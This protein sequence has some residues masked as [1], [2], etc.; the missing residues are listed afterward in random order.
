MKSSTVLFLAIFGF[1][2]LA[3][4]ATDNRNT[5]VVNHYGIEQGLTSI[6]IIDLD[7]DDSGLI[8]LVTSDGLYQFDGIQFHKHS[9]LDNIPL[10]RK[11]SQIAIHGEFA[12]ISINQQLIIY[13]LT[14]GQTAHYLLEDNTARII[15]ILPFSQTHSLVGTSNGLYQVSI[16]QFMHTQ[17]QKIQNSTNISFNTLVNYNSSKALVSESKGQ[18][19]IYD[20][21]TQKLTQI[22]DL[23]EE[24]SDIYYD[25][26]KKHWWLLLKHQIVSLETH[27]NKWRVKDTIIPYPNT[28]EGMQL[29]TSHEDNLYLATRM[30][31]LTEMRLNGKI[32]PL[33]LKT[34]AGALYSD[35][36]ITKIK[37]DD[38]GNLWI[39]SFDE[40]L[41]KLSKE[42]QAMEWLT[43]LPHEKNQL[44]NNHVRAV[45]MTKN[46]D[47]WLGFYNQ[48]ITRFSKEQEKVFQY[49]KNKTQNRLSSDIIWDFAEDLS[50]P[51]LWIATHQTGVSCFDFS[52]ENFCDLSQFRIP[53][54]SAL[55]V[56]ATQ[57]NKW[58]AMHGGLGQL[59]D[60]VF[61]YH[62][63]PPAEHEDKPTA[64]ALLNLTIIDDEVFA[65]SNRGLYV[66][67]QQQKKLQRVPGT[68]SMH[69]NHLLK[70][71]Q[72]LFLATDDGLFILDLNHKKLESYLPTITHNKS[73]VSM[74][75]LENNLWVVGEREIIGINIDTHHYQKVGAEHLIPTQFYLGATFQDHH[76]WLLGSSRG[77]LQINLEQLTTDIHTRP[78]TRANKLIIRHN[79]KSTHLGYY[80]RI[81]DTI[82]LPNKSDS[83]HVTLSSSFITGDAAFQYR[84]NEGLWIPTRSQFNLIPTYWRYGENHLSF[85]HIQANGVE[86]Y[87]S[88]LT[89]IKPTP[90]WH[91]TLAYITYVILFILGN[92]LFIQWRHRSSQL[93]QKALE[94]KIEERTQ[95]LIIKNATIN[96]QAKDLEHLVESKDQMFN[97]VTHELKTP[98]ALMLGPLQLLKD[99]FNDDESFKWFTI[100]QRNGERL[101]HSIDTLLDLQRYAALQ[102]STDLACNVTQVTEYLVESFDSIINQKSL[103]LVK[104]IKSDVW[105]QADAISIEKIIIN[106]LSNAFKY[107]P[108]HSRILLTIEYQD[109]HG[110]IQVEDSGPGIPAELRSK[111]FQPFY[112]QTIHQK[113]SGSGV[114]LAL[115]KKIVD[116][117]QGEIFITAS[118]NEGSIF[119]VQL[120]RAKNLPASSK[121]TESVP[122]ISL[123]FA[124]QELQYAELDNSVEHEVIR[125]NKSKIIVIEDNQELSLMI[126]S[127][128]KAKYWVKTAKDGQEGI[129][130]AKDWLPDLVISDWMM[131]NKDGF[132][133]CQSLKQYKQTM[134]IPILIV[135]AK[136]DIKTK[137]TAYQE[138]ANA[139]LEK[140]FHWQELEHLVH[141]LLASHLRTKY[142]AS[143][144]EIVVNSQS[145]NQYENHT[146]IS[147]D[148]PATLNNQEKKEL[149]AVKKVIEEHYQDLNFNTDKLAD[150]LAMGRRTLE[151]RIKKLTGQTPALMIRHYRLERAK[152][153]LE[154]GHSVTKAALEVGFSQSS[155]FSRLF[156]RYFGFS[157]SDYQKRINQVRQN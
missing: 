56:L 154:S 143:F 79:G 131:P 91:S 82:E 59:N 89:V 57:Q 135:T 63:I 118:Q 132:E 1:F 93:K 75:L 27:Q 153:L 68:E 80:P 8:W 146:P 92:I 10:A 110:I 3:S 15:D 147:P 23:N 96:Q 109:N 73:I 51:Y 107:T 81:P 151:R 70:N 39:A 22:T 12:W 60:T 145:Q 49:T 119:T 136:T 83:L 69:I 41:F 67:K 95:D 141:T 30:S 72:N 140:P 138:L 28:I 111:I 26:R 66:F 11:F 97:D 21:T 50:E 84:L 5:Y 24:V 13:N 58:F 105:V 38:R 87:P 76:H 150:N 113:I 20:D 46:H 54:K 139:F 35:L 149:L 40:G 108:E 148:E 17:G 78:E 124:L 94:H 142:Q 152:C 42:Q 85:R 7:I 100:A 103:S 4:R 102:P 123:N 86:S 19:F 62:A 120:P 9:L 14:N 156:S 155:H 31:G 71:H 116:V 45:A 74:A 77:L 47:L 106:L 43:R 99:K 126:Q 144:A 88:N 127:M 112:R 53:E 128:L 25:N 6:R 122:E 90:W 130:L 64:L 121:H 55:S 61:Q 115:V 117:L 36:R 33:V 29:A 133:V 134:D 101:L 114:G 18:V 37:R 48:G 32:N 52:Q 137:L 125:K 65:G 98:I 157:P 34:K 129:T 2:S 104:N 44:A 16:D